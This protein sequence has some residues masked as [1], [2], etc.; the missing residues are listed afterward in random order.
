MGNKMIRLDNIVNDTDSV[1]T[2]TSQLANTDT[3]QSVIIDLNNTDLVNRTSTSSTSN[4][5]SMLPDS[6]N[7]LKVYHQNICGLKYKS[8]EFLNFLYPNYP[9]IICSTEHH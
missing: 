6:Q 8:N 4:V 2:D 7:S 3:C 5:Y 1:N 9:H